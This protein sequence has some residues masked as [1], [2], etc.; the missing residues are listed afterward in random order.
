LV[1]RL[2]RPVSAALV[3]R[4][5]QRSDRRNTMLDGIGTW[6]RPNAEDDA[7]TTE[8]I[9]GVAQAPWGP[10][11]VAVS[12]RGLVGLAVHSA[13]E[14]F[15]ADYFRRTYLEPRRRPSPLLDH[16][17]GAVEEFLAGCPTALESLPLDL[18]VHSDWDRTVYDAVRRISWGEA[19][20]YGRI[21]TA[22]GRR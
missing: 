8:F 18:F 3:P 19:T 13:Q 2:R 4:R 6:T 22:I 12:T 11:H 15:V 1:A 17:I 9:V 5:P 7:M 20:S 10:V 14:A 16:A 21:A